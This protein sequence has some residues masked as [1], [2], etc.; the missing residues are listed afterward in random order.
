MLNTEKYR[1]PNYKS[2]TYI[3][4][5]I[6]IIGLFVQFDNP[7]KNATYDLFDGLI[8]ITTFT[9]AYLWLKRRILLFGLAFYAVSWN[10]ELMTNPLIV[11]ENQSLLSYNLVIAGLI[12]HV[13]AV[14]CLVVG[15]IDKIK[16]EYLTKRIELNIRV[17]LGLVLGISG[18]IQILTRII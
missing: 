1:E 6:L 10:I 9:F 8:A 15:F 16:I 14:I 12:L 13:L 17:I 5:L 11:I 2:I 3:C 4:S 18:L 7:T